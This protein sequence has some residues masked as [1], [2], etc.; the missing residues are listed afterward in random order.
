M[1]RE[2]EQQLIDM[3]VIPASPLAE[4]SATSNTRDSYNQLP[5]YDEETQEYLF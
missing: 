2:L 3:G 1:T 4:L 5:S